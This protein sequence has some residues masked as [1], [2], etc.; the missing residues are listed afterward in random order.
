MAR[1]QTRSKRKA[2]GG[3]YVA[4][5][6]NR[7]SELTRLPTHTKLAEN[8]NTFVVPPIKK[9]VKAIHNNIVRKKFQ[10]TF[11]KN[12]DLYPKRNNVE[13]VFSALKRT[14]L[15]RIVSKNYMTK[16]KEK[17]HLK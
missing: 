8:N 13:G 12:E 5:R 1:S 3:R 9:G 11:Y 4:G 14:I 16:K 17:L 15:S 6:S 2:T 10:E 7:R